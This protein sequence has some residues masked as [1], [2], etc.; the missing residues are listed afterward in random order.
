MSPFKQ[1]LV[2]GVLLLIAVA[3][4]LGLIRV[5]LLTQGRPLPAPALVQVAHAQDR[6][7]DTVIGAPSVTPKFINQVLAKAHSPA[8]GTGQALYD[9]GKRYQIDPA[10]ALAFFQHESGYGKEGMAARTHSLG[11][12]R[13]MPE[14]RCLEEGGGYATFDSWQQGYGAW[15][16]LIGD[17]YIRE[18]GCSTV[19]QIIPHY[20]PQADHNDEFAYIQSVQT[21]VEGYRAGRTEV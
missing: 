1:T 15:Y 6:S 7:P 20:A 2:T 11:N 18:W 21:A 19:E 16:R 8:S 4:V 5:A 3:V 13:C 9:L 14:Y 17:L 10:Y 12:L